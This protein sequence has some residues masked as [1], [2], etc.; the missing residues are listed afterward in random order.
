MWY[1]SDEKLPYDGDVYLFLEDNIWHNLNR[2]SNLDISPNLRISKGP[3]LNFSWLKK[4]TTS[5]M[6]KEKIEESMPRAIRFK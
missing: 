3:S 6:N 4:M 5:I 2:T 1:R